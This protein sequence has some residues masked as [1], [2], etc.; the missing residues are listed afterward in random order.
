MKYFKRLFKFAL[1]FIG[2]TI[3][4][5]TMFAQQID[6]SI[7]YKAIASGNITI[8]D[9]Q[10]ALINKTNSNDK[11]AFEGALLMKKADLVKPKGEKLKLFKEGRR[12][13]ETMIDKDSKNIEYRFLRLQIQEHAP[14]ILGYKK[15]MDDD[16]KIIVSSYDS[17]PDALKQ[18]IL[19]YSKQS[20][21]IKTAE[22][23]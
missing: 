16:K 2:F 18:A 17:L 13:L 9:Q 20:D 8:V 11:E 12:K 23:K 1:L 15:N 4:V 14:G 5:T 22:L 10:I 21:I 7:F 19:D 6:R 3:S